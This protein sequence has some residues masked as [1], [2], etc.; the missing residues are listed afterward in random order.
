MERLE[1]PR[2]EVQQ[3]WKGRREVAMEIR[4]GPCKVCGSYEHSAETCDAVIEDLAYSSGNEMCT[5]YPGDFD[6]PRRDN[7]AFPNMYNPD[8]EDHSSFSWENNNN[9]PGH[10]ATF[11]QQQSLKEVIDEAV[12]QALAE[13][14]AQV[15]VLVGINTTL[16]EKLEGSNK[17]SDQL[18]L[19]LENL[20]KRTEIEEKQ[21]QKQYER[22]TN[23][24][25]QACATHI[26]RSGKIVDNKVGMDTNSPH[27]S[28]QVQEEDQDVHLEEWNEDD[29]QE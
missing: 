21:H 27:D 2:R 26:L 25:E 29:V 19:S 1:L 20:I 15:K 16:V 23:Q 7:N 22:L 8:L 3:P 28:V 11:Q 10:I 6:Q 18:A 24:L 5:S 14:N 13:M 9:N 12:M 4:P 17:K